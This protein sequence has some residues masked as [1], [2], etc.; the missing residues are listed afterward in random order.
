MMRH[1]KCEKCGKTINLECCQN[2]KAAL[3]HLATHK[4]EEELER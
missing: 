1:W 3:G 4:Q 2:A